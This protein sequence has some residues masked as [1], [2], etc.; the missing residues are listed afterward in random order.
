MLCLS[1][2]AA[3]QTEFKAYLNKEQNFRLKGC[4]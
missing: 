2:E 1:S 4:A 3:D